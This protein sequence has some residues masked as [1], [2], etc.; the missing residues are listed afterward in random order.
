M[1]KIIAL[2]VFLSLVISPFAVVK[3]SDKKSQSVSSDER[4]IVKMVDSKVLNQAVKFGATYLEKK[5]NL[6]LMD[7]PKSKSMQ[8]FLKE[9]RKNPGVIY[10]EPDYKIQL[11]AAPNDPHY[12]K[13]WHLNTIGA[14]K[15]WNSSTGSNTIVAFN[16]STN[17]L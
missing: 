16:S 5:S 10:A 2:L 9:I 14:E 6:I 4:V 12:G 17:P 15:A 11:L 3:A 13:Q 7:K 8:A 1:K